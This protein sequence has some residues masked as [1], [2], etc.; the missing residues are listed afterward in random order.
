MEMDRAYPF[1]TKIKCHKTEA[2]FWNP[3]GKG[4]GG[5]PRNTWHCDHKVD[6]RKTGHSWSQ[7]ER[8]A[9]NKISSKLLLMA[10]AQGGVMGL[11]RQLERQTD[12]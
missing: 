1:Q 6:I 4:K 3:Q 10:Y 12:R 2:L 8:M 9:W 5:Q 11:D 7:L